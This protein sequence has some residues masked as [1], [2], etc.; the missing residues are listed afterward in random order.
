MRTT[1]RLP[2]RLALL[3]ALGLCMAA[4]RPAYR[5]FVDATA[6]RPGGPLGRRFYRDPTHH[7]SSF[8]IALKRLALTSRDRLLEVGFGG[9]Q[10]LER[11]L[12]VVGSAAGIDHSADM[13][14]LTSERNAQAI[15]AGRLQ[16][17]YGDVH[18]LPWGA[19]EFTCAAGLNMF[20]FV[21]RPLDLLAELHRVLAPGGRLVIVTA[22]RSG[23]RRMGP[24]APALRTYSTDEMRT[25]LLSA[26]F[27]QVEVEEPNWSQQ[28]AFALKG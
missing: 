5:R 17:I 23:L 28:V 24:W 4:A 22:D 21:E 3:T 12:Q 14:A 16:L 27:Q 10:F 25:M 19:G 2:L 20:F 9:G 8:D 6:R 11:A 26:G 13:L 7:Y 15:V 18:R 1:L